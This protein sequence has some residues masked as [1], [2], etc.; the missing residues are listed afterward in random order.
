MVLETASMPL[1][2]PSTILAFFLVFTWWLHSRPCSFLLVAT[3]NNQQP[4]NPLELKRQFIV[5]SDMV[6]VLEKPIV[7]AK[8]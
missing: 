5:D 1:D 3:C 4:L 7:H 2:G 6:R 8:A